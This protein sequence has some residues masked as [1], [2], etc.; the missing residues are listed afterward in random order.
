MSKVALALATS[1]SPS[2]RQASS[3]N[4]AASKMAGQA[5]MS[6]V[7]SV[8]SAAFRNFSKVARGDCVLSFGSVGAAASRGAPPL[9]TSA[10]WSLRAT[11]SATRLETSTSL[12]RPGSHW[13][14]MNF[15]IRRKASSLKVSAAS[16]PN[17]AHSKF[18]V[19]ALFFAARFKLLNVVCMSLSKRASRLPR[20]L[21]LFSATKNGS[22]QRNPVTSASDNDVDK[23]LVI[24][25]WRHTLPTAGHVVD[26]REA[27]RGGDEGHL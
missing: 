6:F 4:V 17:P 27:G 5:A 23:A 14:G 8:S 15:N 24:S 13:L 1:T 12:R 7:A 16:P 3:T 19:S 11:R 10:H 20:K 22:L 21:Q 25:V 2:W 26:S 9:A 18:K